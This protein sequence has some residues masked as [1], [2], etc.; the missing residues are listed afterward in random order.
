[1]CVSIPPLSR[2][3]TPWKFDY[4]LFFCVSH[5]YTLE[6]LLQ[7]PWSWH[8]I[9]FPNLPCINHVDRWSHIYMSLSTHTY[10][11]VHDIRL[12]GPQTQETW[13][14]RLPRYNYLCPHTTYCVL[15][16]HAFVVLEA[17]PKQCSPTLVS[18]LLYVFF[19]FFFKTTHFFFLFD[20]EFVYWQRMMMTCCFLF[21]DFTVFL[22][23]CVLLHFCRHV[24]LMF[25]TRIYNANT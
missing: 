2:C 23:T 20:F 7:L 25:F 17:H 5:T 8:L 21:S 9:P 18:T 11:L 15:I 22:S 4:F 10:F 24:A 3:V 6:L 1:M 19:L 12:R 13:R 16:L 14:P